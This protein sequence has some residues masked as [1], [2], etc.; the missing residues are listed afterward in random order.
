MILNVNNTLFGCN[1]LGL[2]MG[3][4]E[5]RPEFCCLEG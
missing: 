3:I 5:F 4:E 2:K 1:E